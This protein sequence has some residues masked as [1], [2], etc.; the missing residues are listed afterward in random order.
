MDVEN[1]VLFEDNHLLVVNK[2]NNIPVQEDSS[3][4]DDF[5]NILKNYLKEKYKKPGN[6]FLGLVHRLDRPTS[7][8]M[9]FAKTSK[10]AAR[11]CEFIKMGEFEKKYLAVTVGCPEEEKGTLIH[12]LKKNPITNTVN[13]VTSAT[14]DA[15]RAE[16]NFKVLEKGKKISLLQVELVTGRGHQIRVQFSHS[17]FPIFG[18]VRYGGNIA[19]G[20][21]LAL[22][23]CELRF[24]H[25]VTKDSMVF[26]C[27]PDTNKE[28]WKRF[29]LERYLSIQLSK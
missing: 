7:G 2:P 17:G 27:H 21:D 10:S 15:K 24:P 5:L 4:D 14:E 11:L 13:V 23:A 12:Y 28:P 3:G 6:V 16:L 1:L 8:V 29:D 22:H 9:V 18:D 20:Y 19:K 25:P 26:I